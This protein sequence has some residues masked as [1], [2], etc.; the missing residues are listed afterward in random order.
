MTFIISAGKISDSD[1]TSGSLALKA[2]WDCELLKYSC[3]ESPIKV[4]SSLPKKEVLCQLSGDAACFHSENGSWLECLGAWKKIV[5]LIVAPSSDG[6]I[7]G[8]ASAY[9]SLCADLSV[10]L[11]G[12]V[13]LGG[14]WDSRYRSLDGLPW[15]GWLPSNTSENFRS[16]HLL[17]PFDNLVVAENLKRRISSLNL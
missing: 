4:L 12:I 10:P 13:Q 6:D 14:Q 7:P 2:F 8:V 15:C 5:I 1:M 3:D 9:V 11:A 16:D 17:Y